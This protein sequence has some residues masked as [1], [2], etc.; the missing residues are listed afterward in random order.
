MDR[1]SEKYRVNKVDMVKIHVEGAELEVIRGGKSLLQRAR[2]V[3]VAVHH[4]QNSNPITEVIRLFK[5]LG[6]RTRLR[7]GLIYSFNTS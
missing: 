7:G 1:I 4:I 3:V 2:Y 6:F 5:R